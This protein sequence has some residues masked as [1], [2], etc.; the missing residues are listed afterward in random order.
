M[1]RHAP[2]KVLV[3][4]VVVNGLALAL[5]VLLLPGVEE[6]TDHPVLGYLALGALFGLVNAFLKPAMQFLAL[7]F[8]FGSIGLVVIIVDTFVFWLLDELTPTLLSVD[9]FGWV[10]LGGVTLG[11]LS[12]LLDNI[13]GLAPPILSDH[14]AD[15]EAAT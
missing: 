3:A 13:F 6:N 8:L 11:I 14:P 15:P 2:I 5:T 12:F 10:I 7:P 4:R 9:G 1:K